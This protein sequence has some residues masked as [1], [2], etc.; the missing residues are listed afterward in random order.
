MRRER[1]AA[2]KMRSAEAIQS[3]SKK[4][5]AETADRKQE[6]VRKHRRRREEGEGEHSKKTKGRVPMSFDQSFYFEF[7]FSFLEVTRELDKPED[8]RL[9]QFQGTPLPS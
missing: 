8:F 4:I 2:E 5:R 1:R 9:D 7:V 6:T 3:R